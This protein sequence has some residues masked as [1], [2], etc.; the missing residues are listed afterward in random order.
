[1]KLRVFGIAAGLLTLAA[2]TTTPGKTQSVNDSVPVFADGQC[3]LA[4]WELKTNQEAEDAGLKST[5]WWGKENWEL[6]LDLAQSVSEDSPLYTG[7]FGY[8]RFVN[9]GQDV[10]LFKGAKSANSGNYYSYAAADLGPNGPERY[11]WI[12]DTDIECKIEAPD[13]DGS[14]GGDLG[15]FDDLPFGIVNPT[16]D[17]LVRF[18]L[19]VLP[20]NPIA[21]GGKALQEYQN[22]LVDTVFEQAPV[23]RFSVVDSD[24]SSATVAFSRDGLDFAEDLSLTKQ[25]LESDRLT[26][27]IKGFA[28]STSAF[29]YLE[30]RY[31]EFGNWESSHGGTALGVD[32]ALSDTFRIGAFGN[33]GNVSVNH[34][35]RG[36]G[37]W[38]SNGW[39]GGLTATYAQDNF[40]AQGLLGA[41]AFSG[42]HRRYLLSVG[43]YG[44]GTAKGTQ[45]STSYVGALRVGSPQ[46]LGSVVLEPQLTGTWNHNQ[47]HP[48]SESGGDFFNI[49]Y[50][51]YSD[52]FLQTLLAVKVSLPVNSGDRALFNP[53]VRVGWIA[54]WDLNNGDAKVENIYTGASRGIP[55]VQDDEHGLLLEGGLDYTINNLGSTSFK[56][57]AKGGIELWDNDQK[58]TDW[59]VSGGVTF[60]FG[61]A[62]KGSPKA[63]VVEEVIVEPAPEPAPVRGLW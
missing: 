8:D 61:G 28:G 20:R 49:H 1:M 48:W 17:D 46:Q 24:D 3:K 37:N 22:D 54:D 23:R 32:Y 12:F 62:P 16:T 63:E 56:L 29:N 6:A 40:Y 21:T 43:N 58:D 15:K 9:G 31:G 4:F 19:N 34:I 36:G 26:A 27:W 35:N 2:A 11:R 60:T 10:I 53:F 30:T 18:A 42:T 25:Y 7:Q 45:E 52:N 55:I 13:V 14:G 59:R 39:G 47:D 57:Y 51:S 5:R 33:W 38:N 41:S 44:G 50:K